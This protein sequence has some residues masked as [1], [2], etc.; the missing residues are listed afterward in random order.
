MLTA[1]VSAIKALPVHWFGSEPTPDPRTLSH[2][3]FV[4]E[5]TTLDSKIFAWVHEIK[6]TFDESRT[7]I[8]CHYDL[9]LTAAE[10]ETLLTRFEVHFGLQFNRFERY[11]LLQKGVGLSQ[12]HSLAKQAIRRQDLPAAS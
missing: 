11:R 9:G 4:M 3:A 8:N 7:R 10:C 12:L 2:K 5:L 6:Y 1:V